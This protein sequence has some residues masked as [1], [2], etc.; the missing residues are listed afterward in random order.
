MA[1]IKDM[2]PAAVIVLRDGTQTSLPAADLVPGDLVQLSLGQK[3][4][5]DLRLLEVS[6][7]L[8]FDRS[9]LTGEVRH[10][11]VLRPLLHGSLY[12]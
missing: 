2:L 7:D 1:S 8:K 10:G 9:V 11:S 6:S 4:P 3:V 12:S 5:A